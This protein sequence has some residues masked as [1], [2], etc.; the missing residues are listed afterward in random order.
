MCEAN[1]YLAEWWLAK[2]GEETARPLLEDVRDNCRH[3]FIEYSAAR[4][5]LTRLH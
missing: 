4:A 5:E 1:F 2:K 3:D